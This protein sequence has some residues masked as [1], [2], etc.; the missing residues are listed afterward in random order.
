MLQPEWAA[1]KFEQSASF[2][3]YISCAAIVIK[4]W[5]HCGWWGMDI[6][7]LPGMSFRHILHQGQ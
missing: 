6:Q 4:W 3:G 7:G 1:A 5:Y 2:L